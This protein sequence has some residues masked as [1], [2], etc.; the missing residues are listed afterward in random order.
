MWRIEIEI[1]SVKLKRRGFYQWG[2]KGSALASS[3]VEE[4]LQSS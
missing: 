2:Q 1:E 3:L 4:N